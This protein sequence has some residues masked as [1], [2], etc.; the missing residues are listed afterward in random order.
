M[1]K[2]KFFRWLEFYRWSWF[3]GI[4]FG[5][6]ILFLIFHVYAMVNYSLYSRLLFKLSTTV[7]DHLVVGVADWGF[8]FFIIPWVGS[9]FIVNIVL[10][11]GLKMTDT[12]SLVV[13]FILALIYVYLLSCILDWIFSIVCEKIK[14]SKK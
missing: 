5:V 12:F 14:N 8:F 10:N 13:F 3:K 7:F 6:L 9:H 2:L 1:A 11:L 4:V